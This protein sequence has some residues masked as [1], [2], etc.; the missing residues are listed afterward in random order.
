M[1]QCKIMEDSGLFHF[2]EDLFYNGNLGAPKISEGNKFFC[3]GETFVPES[4]YNCVQ[5]QPTLADT[6]RLG[7]ISFEDG[8][9]QTCKM[10]CN[11][12]RDI[13]PPLDK[14]RIERNRQK[15]EAARA[16]EEEEFDPNADMN[17]FLN[18]IPTGSSSSASAAGSGKRK[19]RSKRGK[20]QS[21]RNRCKS[22]K[23]LKKSM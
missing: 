13:P 19:K 20:K 3:S 6:L 9:R 12:P 1:V 5:G 10:N 2:G 18:S 17:D 8:N 7:Y 11:P 16:A 14:K 21:R 15:V 4:R 23:R 22:G